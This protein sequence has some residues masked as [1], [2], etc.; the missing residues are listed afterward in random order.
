MRSLPALLGALLLCLVLAGCS[1]RKLVFPDSNFSCEVPS[2]W[3]MQAK[4][5]HQID[6]HR[7]TGGIFVVVAKPLATPLKIPDPAFTKSFH[8]KLVADG[9]E[10]VDESDSPFQGQPAYTV[11]FRKV[12]NGTMTY[13]RSVNFATARFRYALEIAERGADPSS[14]TGLMAALNSFRLLAAAP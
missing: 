6:A 11:T 5:G 4:P 13:C 9:Y 3:V 2:T 8:D 14:D 1:P 7:L 10:V 12:I